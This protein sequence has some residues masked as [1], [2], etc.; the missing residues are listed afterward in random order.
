LELVQEDNPVLANNRHTSKLSD[1]TQLLK[2]RLSWL[3]VFSALTAYFMGTTDYSWMKILMLTLGGF[4]VTGSSNAFN[5]IIE[6]DLD[7]LM[8][9]THNRPMPQ[10]RLSKVEA[11]IF[12]A[13]TGIVGI[14]VLWVFMNPLSGILGLLALLSYVAVYT[15]MKRITPFAVFVGAFPGAVPPLLGWVAASGDIGLYGLVLFSIQFIWQFPHFWSLAWVLEDD[16]LKAGFR[17]LPSSQGKSKAS[18]FQVLAYTIGL[19]PLGL[20]PFLFRMVS[21]I[22]TAILLICGIYFSLKAIMLYRSLDRADARA[23]MFASFI[24]LPVVQVVMTLDHLFILPY[25]MR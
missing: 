25:W 20:L 14:V 10:G 1:Y 11:L 7:R 12:S 2:L 23:L 6:R 13:L 24:Y 16:Y 21:P 3:V 9:R 19:I 5:Q 15:P 22:A 17:M 18:A 4:L 8:D